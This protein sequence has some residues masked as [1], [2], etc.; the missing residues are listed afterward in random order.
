M[1]NILYIFIFIFGLTIGS[2]LNCL[3][4]RLHSGQGMGGRSMCPKCKKTIA[5]YD[6]LPVLS[7]L[8]LGGKCRHCQKSISWQYPLVELTVGVLFVLAA[9]LNFDKFGFY[10][11][12]LFFTDFRSAL[13]LIRD[14]LAIA[15]MVIIFVYDLR[16][17]L[18]LDIVSIPAC[19]IF[20][21]INLLLGFSL[22][23]IILA[24]LLGGGFFLAQFL[25]SRGRWIGGGDIRMG[26][27]MGIILG[28]ISKML[29]A[30]MASYFIGSIVGILL[31]LAGKKKL[32]SKLPMGVFLS[33]GLLI[34]LF[35]GN[36]IIKWYF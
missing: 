9:Y 17:Y 33:I 8:A 11:P 20:L 4:W 2:F 25:V 24:S 30:L 31:I 18:I 36:G 28:S 19:I 7:F 6:N 35:F 15:F 29:I 16:W 32:G 34:A 13:F 5:W 23:N 14:W 12:I 10:D 27:L 22:I 21:L 1:N 3:I 26:F